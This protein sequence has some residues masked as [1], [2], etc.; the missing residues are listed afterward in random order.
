M[1]VGLLGDLV[2]LPG[3]LGADFSPFTAKGARDRTSPRAAC[4]QVW[5]L[6]GVWATTRLGTRSHAFLDDPVDRRFGNAQVLRWVD[7]GHL[8]IGWIVEDYC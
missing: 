8:E 5:G 1:V 6:P 2:A 3:R 7:L 4:Q